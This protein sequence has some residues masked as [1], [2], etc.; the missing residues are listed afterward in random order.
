[1]KSVNLNFLESSGPLQACNGT[2]L[3]LY[4]HSPLIP[5]QFSLYPPIFKIHFFIILPCTLRSSNRYRPCRHSEQNFCVHSHL[6]RTSYKPAHQ[7]SLLSIGSQIKPVYIVSSLR[8]ILIL[9]S[10]ASKPGS[11]KPYLS[12]RL[13]QRNPVRTFISTIR[14]TSRQQ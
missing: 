11:S 13:S 3:P 12:F 8:T 5:I 6:S 14:P 7:H 2:A 1:M 10:Q 9:S 4:T